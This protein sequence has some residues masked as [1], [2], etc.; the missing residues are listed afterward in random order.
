MASKS[1]SK[2]HGFYIVGEDAKGKRHPLSPHVHSKS[3]LTDLL[4]TLQHSRRGDYV[5]I[6]IAED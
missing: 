3:S 2:K 4:A 5:R 1:S 6:Y